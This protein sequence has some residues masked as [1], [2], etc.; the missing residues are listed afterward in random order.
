MLDQEDRNSP[1]PEA[2]FEDEESGAKL[3]VERKAIIYPEDYAKLHKYD[4]HIIEMLF[5]RLPVEITN[6]PYVL[7]FGYLYGAAF[8]DI[9]RH[10][11]EVV[12]T[13]TS[14]SPELSK[15]DRIDFEVDSLDYVLRKK[16]SIDH[17][18]FAPWNALVITSA[19][20]ERFS[21]LKPPFQNYL[22]CLMPKMLLAVRD[23]C[24][25]YQDSRKILLINR[26]GDAR[27]T[28]PDAWRRYFAVCSFD[29]PVDEIWDSW[30]EAPDY[31]KES[32]WVHD[33]FYPCDNVELNV[34]EDIWIENLCY[35]NPS[36]NRRVCS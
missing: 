13:I 24:V 25:S 21:P 3:V 26:Y 18:D 15:N 4:H 14:L 11:E 36:L 28:N 31:S 1:Q 16:Q 7:E 27:R 8:G 30:I 2:L 22:N 20:N 17:N 33:K 12:K 29:I 19:G 6:G 34:A 9:I 35:K 5:S 23:K 32:Y 10:A